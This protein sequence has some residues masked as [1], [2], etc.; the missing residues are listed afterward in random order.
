MARARS[1]YTNARR[2]PVERARY[3]A[4]AR[5]AGVKARLPRPWLVAD[6]TALV[7]AAAFL[8]VAG[9]LVGSAV[10]DGVRQLGASVGGVFGASEGKAL[11]LPTAGG[12]GNAD[13]LISAL[14]DFTRDPKLQIAGRVPSFAIG[15]GRTVEIVVNGAVVGTTQLD[16]SGSFS[17]DATLKDGPNV[18]GVTLLAGRDVVARSSYTVVL[19]RQPP[20]ISI[21]RPGEQEQIT[22]P[23]VTVEGRT[24]TGASITVNGQ[25][26]VPGPDGAFSASIPASPGPLALTI[27]A[28][29]RAGNETTVKGTVNVVAPNAAAPTTVAVA[30]DRSKVRPGEAVLAEIRLSE[31]GRP[32]ANV[33]VTLSVGVITIGTAVTDSGGIAHIGF[34]APPNEGDAAVVVLAAGAAGRAPLTVAR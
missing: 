34:A 29:D 19:D 11:D 6:A 24:E 28:R 14:P 4:T 15:S 21:T 16:Q 3:R 22:G 18:I 7:V 5:S 12:I 2:A 20:T 1:T 25:T 27:I 32:K 31:N 9:P 10:D 23:N 30:L 13:P 26:V 8:M 33:T 17:A